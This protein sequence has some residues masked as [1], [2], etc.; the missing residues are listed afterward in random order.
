MKNI[1]SY[2]LNSYNTYNLH[3][4]E[5]TIKRLH[6]IGLDIEKIWTLNQDKHWSETQKKLCRIADDVG[7]TLGCPDFV[8][9]P[10]NWMSTTNTC[11]GINVSNALTFNTHNWRN[12]VLLQRKKPRNALYQTW[13][14]IGSNE[15]IKQAT[16]IVLGKPSKDYYT[17][18]D[19][20]I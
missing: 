18:K 11:C 13:E 7:V 12:L 2:G 3:I 6:N 10:I 5:Y 15:D 14:E 17:F 19:A 8:N 9:V 16:K 4:N 1:K 20:G